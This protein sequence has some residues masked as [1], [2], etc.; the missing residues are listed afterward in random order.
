MHT[1]VLAFLAAVLLAEVFT[2]IVI[3]LARRIGAVDNPTIR[4]V[5]TNPIPRIGGVAIY[6]ATV[7]VIVGMLFLDNTVGERFRDVRLQILTFLGVVSGIFLIGLVDDLKGLPARVKFVAELLGAVVLCLVGVKIGHIGILNT[8]DLNLGWLGY[9]ITVLWIVGIT[10]AVNMSDGLD[11]LAAGVSAITCGVIAAFTLHGSIIHDGVARSNDVMMA[12]FSLAM[13]G[14]LAGFL[15]FNFN[16]AKVFMGDCGSLFLGFTIGAAS[17][18]CVSKSATLVALALPALALGIPIFDTLFSMLRRF[19]ERRSLFAPDRSHFHH[20]LLELGFTQRH[21]VL[22]IYTA[23]LMAA[24]LGLFMMVRESLGSLIVFGIV[25]FLI[26]CLFRL[27]GVVRL[28]QTVARLRKKYEYS[29]HERGEQRAFEQLQLRF[30][31][32]RDAKQWREALCEAADRMDFA[33]V[34]LKVIHADGQ[35]DEEIW[36]SPRTP[37]DLSRIITFTI[38]LGWDATRA[39]RHLE[40]AVRI[41][42][43]ME[44]AGHRASLFGRL[45]DE[46]SRSEGGTLCVEDYVDT[47]FRRRTEPT[48][49]SVR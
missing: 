29:S 6:F 37:Q 10:N 8:F 28:R 15:I 35:I 14:S 3:R 49:E 11:G 5:H 4:S 20:R 40:I 18:M 38:P 46:S 19:L 33:W 22:I 25:L 1:Y 31:Q 2:P 26:V 27:V 48:G 34:A 45:I 13:V 47:I 23:T 32:V 16:P 24:G 41:N 12:V 44:G 7:G 21:A 30:R 9:P 39:S 43:S 36:R 42:G 17:V